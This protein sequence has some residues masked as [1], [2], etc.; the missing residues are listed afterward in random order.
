MHCCVAG[1]SVATPTLFVTYSSKGKEMSHYAYG[2]NKNEID[3][4]NTVDD[5]FIFIIENMVKNRL[6]IKEYLSQ[7]KNRFVNDTMKGGNKLV[8]I[9]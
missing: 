3:C 8:E 5:S 1:I 4:I 7:Q 2:D 9:L 6:N